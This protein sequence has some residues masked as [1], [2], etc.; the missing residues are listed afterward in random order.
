MAR[1][2]EVDGFTGTIKEITEEFGLA[3]TTLRK[4]LKTMSLE[5][6]IKKCRAHR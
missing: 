4:R 6:A 1:I 3:E 2:Y 5:E